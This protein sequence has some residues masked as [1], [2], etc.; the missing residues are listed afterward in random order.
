MPGRHWLRSLKRSQ[1][2]SCE[3]RD[4]AGLVASFGRAATGLPFGDDGHDEI[5]AI[6]TLH[7]ARR[8]AFLLN[9]A[10]DR[11]KEEGKTE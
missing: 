7:F 3:G 11:L 10:E 5:G 9:K 6:A 1:K 8:V 2:A 4:V